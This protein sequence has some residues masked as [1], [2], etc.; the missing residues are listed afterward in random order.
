MIKMEESAV[1][2]QV[3]DSWKPTSA[4]EHQCGDSVYPADEELAFVSLR[5][6]AAVM[7]VRTH[8]R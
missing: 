5:T 2:V 1:T 4:P 6:F 7:T 8:G 3:D